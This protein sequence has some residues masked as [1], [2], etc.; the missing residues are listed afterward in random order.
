MS[1]PSTFLN[2][3]DDSKRALAK[4]M[5]RENITV[6]VV[7]N[8]KTADFNTVTRI[9]RIPNWP[10]LDADQT[11]LLIGH[12]VGHALFTDYSYIE[13]LVARKRKGEASKGLMTYF[14]VIEDTRIERKMRTAFP[15]LRRS[16]YNGYQSF[17]KVGPIFMMNS[18]N[19]FVHPV[20]GETMPVTKMR[21]IDRINVHYKLGAFVKVP[22]AQSEL[23]WLDKIDR[24]ISQDDALAIAIELHKLAK[25]K[26]DEENNQS[27]SDQQEKGGEKSDKKDKSKQKPKKSPKSDEDEGP[28][29]SSD[30]DNES[31][32]GDAEE[33][34]SRESDDADES[35]SDSEGSES[36]SDEDA[37]GDSEGG[38]EESDADADA[39]SDKE[40]KDGDSTGDDKSDQTDKDSKAVEADEEDGT[41]DKG[42]HVPNKAK[43][44]EETDAF[45]PKEPASED[46]ASFTDDANQ[47]GLNAAAA[48][49]EK[50]DESQKIIH[51]LM[52]PLTE[53]IVKDRNTPASEW[54]NEGVEIIE[55]HVAQ[56]ADL[57]AFLKANEQAW[58]DAFL[59]TAKH[60][61][62]EFNR[63]KTAKNLARI[64]MGKTGKLNPGKLHAYKFSDD[65]F[66]RSMTVPTGQSHGITMIIDASGSMSGVFGDVLD[67]VML[68]ANFTKQAQIPFEC[69]LFTT[70]A[71]TGWSSN[72]SGYNAPVDR[73]PSMGLQTL[74]LGPS[75]RLVGLV[76]TMS[77]T[78]KKQMK[79]LH[80]F[81]CAWGVAPS[82][83]NHPQAYNAQALAGQMPYASLGSTPLY[84]GLMIGERHLERM[85]RVYKLDKMIN[86]VI[87][88]GQDCENLFYEKQTV[89]SYGKIKTL[90][91][92]AGS[93][94]LVVRDT[95]TKKN[96]VL[97]DE[98]VDHYDS[99]KK[100]FYCPDNGLLHLLLQVNVDRHDCRNVFIFLNPG[101]KR[102]GANVVYSMKYLLKPGVTSRYDRSNTEVA[103]LGINDTVIN[104][105]FDDAS[106]YVVPSKFGVAD[107]V[108]VIPTSTTRLREKDFADLNTSTMSQRKIA[109][110][111]VKSLT[112]AKTNRVFV[113]TVIPFLA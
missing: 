99:S 42:E 40:S 111:F 35:D 60:M 5:A 66:L 49:A 69:Y 22:F 12:E 24:C 28:D 21:L 26:R 34:D 43:R 68:F 96:H 83:Q 31:A 77:P 11:D 63:R 52:K 75:G 4:L 10:S 47:E 30:D 82:L 48:E 38:D 58:N 94:G 87:T 14:N 7:D 54:A 89:D 8:I 106:Q 9:L 23:M 76:D 107:L 112:I 45:T 100:H 6:Q 51:L 65:L 104:K 80:T 50:Q 37:D 84:A 46:P 81:R 56:N 20:T 53:K 105:A 2:S 32:D 71:K 113:N 108:L 15:G 92:S 78:F 55:R 17:M 59:G 72:Y 25:E 41:P 88:D 29:D 61:A 36:D 62:V 64:K 91:D 74:T 86:V 109:G 70:S 18:R 110:A 33:G 79:S 85:K 103:K 98:H 39:D 90:F 97:V 67:Q 44:T 1:N 3:F 57:A 16:F 93:H 95:V 102:S 73:F 19:E 101:G 13:K 27:D